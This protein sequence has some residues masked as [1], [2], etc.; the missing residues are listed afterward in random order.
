MNYSIGYDLDSEFG[1]LIVYN[2][3]LGDGLFFKAVPALS[4]KERAKK[5]MELKEN[6]EKLVVT[7]E[8]R[9]FYESGLP[10]HAIAKG[11]RRIL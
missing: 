4:K 10:K 6:K 11:I 9:G 8:H 2:L 3:H 1:K 7:V 5:Y